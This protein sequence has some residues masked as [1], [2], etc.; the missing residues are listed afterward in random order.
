MSSAVLFL[1]SRTADTRFFLCFRATRIA[2]LGVI[3]PLSVRT[4]GNLKVSNGEY[5]KR[6]MENQSLSTWQRQRQFEYF[7][8]VFGHF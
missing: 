5:V 8:F 3:P 7:V 1:G 2:V 4:K 6:I